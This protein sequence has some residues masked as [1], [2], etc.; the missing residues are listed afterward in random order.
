MAEG[1]HFVSYLRK[2]GSRCWYVYAWR[3][4]PR[5]ATVDGGGQPRLSREMRS[6][7]D[8]ARCE[9]AE[10]GSRTTSGLI[11]DWRRSPEWNALAATTRNTWA[12]PLA[13]IEGKWG[14]H[15]LELW[16][17]PRMVGKVVAWRDS[18]AATPRA[19]DIGITVLSR[20]LEWGRLRARIRINV[21]GGIPSLYGGG[22]RAEIIWLPEDEEQFC[23]SALML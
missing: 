16:N 9:A 2:D 21:A 23:R 7:I 10:L 14:E 15:S 19:A 11:R 4:G 22:D 5:I 6:A 3:G 1:A 13:R 12:V 18:M 17:D 8:E 20:L